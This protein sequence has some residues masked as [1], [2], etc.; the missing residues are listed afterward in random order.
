M[1]QMLWVL[2]VIMPLMIFGLLMIRAIKE[3]NR[4]A[5]EQ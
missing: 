2:A 5:S 3:G 4:E 1:E